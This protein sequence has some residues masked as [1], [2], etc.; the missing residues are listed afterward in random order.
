ME[1]EVIDMALLPGVVSA[2]NR[3]RFAQLKRVVFPPWC[4][5]PPMDVKEYLKTELRE[6]DR[7][8]FLVFEEIRGISQRNPSI[9]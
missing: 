5:G 4:W 9:F 7:R 8:G 2:L 3:R 1:W 6:L